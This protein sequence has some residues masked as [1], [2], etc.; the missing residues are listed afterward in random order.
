M[1]ISSLRPSHEVQIELLTAWVPSRHFIHIMFQQNSW[2]PFPISPSNCSQRSLTYFNNGTYIW[3][4]PPNWVHTWF[5]CFLYTSTSNS[6]Q[7]LFMLLP[8]YILGLSTSSLALLFPPSCE[9][10]ITAS[11]DDGSIDWRRLLCS[12]SL[13][14]TSTQ[15]LNEL[16][17]SSSALLK[18]LLWLSFALGIQ[19][20]CHGLQDAVFPHP[21]LSLWLHHLHSAP[22]TWAFKYSKR[23]VC[24]GSW[25]SCFFCLERSFLWSLVWICLNIKVLVQYCLFWE[26]FHVSSPWDHVCC[27]S[28]PPSSRLRLRSSHHYLKL[29]FFLITVHLQQLTCRLRESRNTLAYISL[30]PQPLAHSKCSVNSWVL[31][32]E[33]VRDDRIDNA[34]ANDAS[35]EVLLSSPFTTQGYAISLFP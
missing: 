12:A 2:F 33:W 7:V 1:Y 27:S 34:H 19:T 9:A 6:S 21:S 11:L 24:S 3:A 35:V 18:I 17:S 5:V 25:P 31:S 20:P 32:V 28:L 10:T 14:L 16:C 30:Y 13:G 26:A 23:I 15:Q 8:K 29:F 4:V 22:S